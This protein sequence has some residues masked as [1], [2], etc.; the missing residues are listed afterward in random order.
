M[1]PKEEEQQEQE[2]LKQQ[3]T[4]THAHTEVHFSLC[5]SF[6]HNS[7]FAWPEQQAYATLRTGYPHHHPQQQRSNQQGTPAAAHKQFSVPSLHPNKDRR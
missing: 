4:H 7:L 2:Q 1:G 5:D 6:I 3:Q